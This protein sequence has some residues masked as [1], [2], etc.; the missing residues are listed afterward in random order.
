G[1]PSF[2]QFLG[3]HSSF[4]I[5]RRFT[6]LRLRLMLCKQD[7][8]CALEQQL[9]A[10]DESDTRLL[11]LGSIRLDE[12]ADRKRVLAE[13]DLVLGEFDVLVDRNERAFA[14]RK[15]KRR[16]L[17]NIR[18]WLED[19]GS[20]ARKETEY[21]EQSDDVMSLEHTT[22]DSLLDSVAIGIEKLLMRL[23]GLLSSKLRTS[24]AAEPNLWIFPRTLL[25]G[26]ARV[27]LACVLITLLFLPIVLING[28]KRLSTR[29]ILIWISATLFIMILTIGTKARTAEVFVAGTTYV[30]VLVVFV[31]QNGSG[32]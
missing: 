11:H 25:Q 27:V 12:N 8:L 32:Q 14:R 22:S 26:L 24:T 23:P 29:L 7:Q 6:S 17:A 20:I 5:F 1:Y 30:T 18:R 9:N 3:S 28:T 21:S 10:I 16:N 19:K 13:I 4:N 2:V 15:A 31:A